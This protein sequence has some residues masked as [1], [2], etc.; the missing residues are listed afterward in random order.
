MIRRLECGSAIRGELPAGCRLCA[1]GAK[2]VLLVTG[3]C[4]AGCFYCPLSEEK[5]GRD[6]IYA[7]ERPVEDDEDILK[8]ARSI[9]ALGTGITGGDPL[10]RVDRTLHYIR[11]LKEEF[12]ERHHIH[13]Y[14]ASG[15][16]ED[17]EA[18]ASAG[19]DEL[20]IH[21]PPGTWGRI[22]DTLYWRRVERAVETGMAVGV[23]IPAVPGME[24][25]IV[26]LIRTV[27]EFGVSFVN[28]NELEF[29]ETNAEELLRRGY[30][31]VD[32]VSSGVA[33][34]EETALEVLRRVD[35]DITVHYCSSSFKDGVQL[36]NRLLRKAANVA[37]DYEEMT[38]DGTLIL[39]V[40]ETEDLEGAWNLLVERFGVP[41]DLM[42]MDR[43]R[44][45]I[46]IAPWILEE[47]AEELPY[48]A[49]EVE[50][51]P[52]WDRLEVERVRLNPRR[53][54]EGGR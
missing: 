45:R 44:N 38:E 15:K 21:P 32:D 43:R 46:N 33:G 14:T 42:E 30:R 51:Y 47:I 11:L 52:T 35:V 3:L 19:L 54:G 1:L 28:L 8:E 48:E 27:S 7:N 26:H 12:G 34:S 9:N 25:D 5:R 31:V 53:P 20:R 22:E 39:G 10:K 18:L 13:L 40:V 23:E 49:Y 17:Y 29:S 16:R 37:R 24:D 50:E 4:D 36:R 41:P 2:M 6:V